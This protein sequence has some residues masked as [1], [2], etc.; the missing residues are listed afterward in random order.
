MELLRK[1]TSAMRRCS[2]FLVSFFLLANACAS[3]PS[4]LSTRKPGSQE[5]LVTGRVDVLLPGKPLFWVFVVPKEGGTAW[6]YKVTG[7]G[8]FFWY[9][10]PGS[11]EIPSFQWKQGELDPGTRTGQAFARFTVPHGKPFVY[12]GTLTI[13]FFKGGRYGIKVFDDYDSGGFARLNEKFPGI[14]KEDVAKSLITL[15]GRL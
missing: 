2:I 15:G 12:I 3:T 10:F 9:L 6:D 11:Y 13:T 4:E 14:K 7:D 1:D 5:V 8:T